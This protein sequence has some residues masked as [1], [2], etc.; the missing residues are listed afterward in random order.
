LPPPLPS[1]LAENAGLAFIGEKTWKPAGLTSR[2]ARSI[3]EAHNPTGRPNRDVLRHFI[4][5]KSGRHRAQWQVDFPPHS[6]EQEAALYLEPCRQLRS[7]LDD[8]SG[9]WWL[10]P[11]TQT[12]LRTAVARLER[13]LASPLAG[14]SPA[15]NWVDSNLLPD[16]S[17]LV[18][19]RDDDYTHGLLRSHAFQLWWKQQ[20]PRL[21]PTEIVRT[22][23]F[24]WPPP[25]LLSSLTR[26]QE[27]H[28]MMITRA[29]RGTGQEQ[30]NSAVAA[31]YGWPGGLAD[32]E[33][34]AHLAELNRRRAG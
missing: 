9:R 1:P 25:A 4:G 26:E 30:I 3:G 14:K 6:T 16:D 29:A 21:S 33:M 34:L 13:Y 20:A 23:P 12:A 2:E 5:L 8:F 17:L 15:W 7:R 18:V 27:E 32:D 10:S 19:A 22:F 24:P 11:H 31:A 28:R